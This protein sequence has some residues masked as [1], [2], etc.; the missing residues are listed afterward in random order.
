[1][2]NPAV[3]EAALRVYF[4]ASE[5]KT[6]S[7]SCLPTVSYSAWNSSITANTSSMALQRHAVTMPIFIGDDV[8]SAKVVDSASKVVMYGDSSGASI[9]RDA[10]YPISLCANAFND[11]W[12]HYEDPL[13]GHSNTIDSFKVEGELHLLKMKT[14]EASESR[15]RALD[16]MYDFLEDAF[17]RNHLRMIDHMLLLSAEKLLKHSL[18]VSF[19]RATSRARKHLVYWKFYE[20]K[21]RESLV[22]NPDAK[23]LLKGLD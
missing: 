11:Y 1:M 4:P 3:R 12:T 2:I 14:Y 5:D 17:E 9:G 21:V 13:F 8:Y 23:K 16:Y 6:D 15:R 19:L 18:S 20:S 10:W 22:G 7:S